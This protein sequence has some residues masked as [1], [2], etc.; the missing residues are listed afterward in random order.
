MLGRERNAASGDGEGPED[1]GGMASEGVA[2]WERLGQI[3]WEVV[4]ILESDGYPEY[5]AEIAMG[6]TMVLGDFLGPSSEISRD[7][8]EKSVTFLDVLDEYQQE[9]V[10]SRLSSGGDILQDLAA[11][12]SCDIESR[13]SAGDKKAVGRPAALKALECYEL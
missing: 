13:Q 5:C 11:V 2:A 12:F 3:V 9:E 6:V 10:F 7:W 4:E 8:K 1:G